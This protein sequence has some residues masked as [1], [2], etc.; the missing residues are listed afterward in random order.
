MERLT[1][2]CYHYMHAIFPL[3]TDARVAMVEAA[4]ESFVL[5]FA[6]ACTSHSNHTDDLLAVMQSFLKQR[7]NDWTEQGLLMGNLEENF[8]S[9]IY[10]VLGVNIDH[11]VDPQPEQLFRNPMIQKC[12]S[13]QASLGYPGERQHRSLS[14]KVGL[15]SLNLRFASLMLA[16]PF[17]KPS[18]PGAESDFKK[19][20]GSHPILP[21]SYPARILRPSQKCFD[22]CS[23]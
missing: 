18:V 20:G 16:Y 11:S 9:D 13:M 15:T 1:L 19:P 22:R 7:S 5:Q 23:D 10:R 12:L 17:K 6:I 3:M 4:T 14:S 21:I 8:L 2:V